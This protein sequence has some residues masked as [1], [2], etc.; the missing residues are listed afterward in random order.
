MNTNTTDTNTT[1]T[2]VELLAKWLGED[3]ENISEARFD[4]WGLTTLE[5][6]NDT[7]AVGTDEECD[8]ACLDYVKETVWAFKASFILGE[9]ELPLA[10]EDAIRAFQEKECESANDALL[11]LVEKTCGIDRFYQ[12]AVGLDGR[13][14]FLAS[15]DGD[16]IDLGNGF[17]A[18]RIG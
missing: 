13:G 12:C 5:V 11:K 6:G 17:F 4:T 3:A 18:Y 1:Q 2:A 15:Y 8:A 9:C 7:Y 16:E 10:L 14:H